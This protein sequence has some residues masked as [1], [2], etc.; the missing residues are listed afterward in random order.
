M[1]DLIRDHARACAAAV[2]ETVAG[3]LRE[4]ERPDAFLLFQEAVR[5]CLESYEAHRRGQARTPPRPSRN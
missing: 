3:C 5:A 4:E 2:L 1:Y